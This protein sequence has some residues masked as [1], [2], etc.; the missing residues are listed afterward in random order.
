MV[1]MAMLGEGMFYGLE[2]NDKII[3]LRMTQGTWA[4]KSTAVA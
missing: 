4:L 2:K 1:D 3:G